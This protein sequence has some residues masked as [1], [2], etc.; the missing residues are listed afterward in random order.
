MTEL[1]SIRDLLLRFYT[2][3]SS[4]VEKTTLGVEYLPLHHTRHTFVTMCIS[5]GLNPV[6]IA[7]FTGH[8]VKVLFDFY[9]GLWDQPSI[10]DF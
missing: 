4:Y 10:P 8:R 7:Q 2:I 3:K 9:A 5:K 6:T 1:P